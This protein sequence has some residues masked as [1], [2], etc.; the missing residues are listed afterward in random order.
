MGS[1]DSSLVQAVWEKGWTVPDYS[2]DLWRRDHLGNYI[3]RDER[4]NRDSEF[5]WAVDRIVPG[6]DDLS[7]LRPLQW[8]AHAA[9]LASD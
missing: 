6:S 4:G 8:R 7:N 9:R 2:E 5:G 3:R 1:V